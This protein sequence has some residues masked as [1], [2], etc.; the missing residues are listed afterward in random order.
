MVALDEQAYDDSEQNIVAF[1]KQA[2][3]NAVG[4]VVAGSSLAAVGIGL[5]AWALLRMRRGRSASGTG[6]AISPVLSSR[7]VGL[8]FN[9]HF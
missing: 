6:A 3:A 8:S 9:T 1:R 4:L 5:G 2:R 7:N